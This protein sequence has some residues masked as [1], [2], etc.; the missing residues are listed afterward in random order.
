M[1]KT[2]DLSA[3][4]RTKVEPPKPIL[5]EAPKQK[6]R[7]GAR[8]VGRPPKPKEEKRDQKV[9]ISFTQTEL[10]RIKDQA[11]LT[12]IATFLLAKLREARVLD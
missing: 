1:K 9:A 12:P 11:G 10:D 4:K 3:Y 5:T 7:G 6:G 8:V 2:T